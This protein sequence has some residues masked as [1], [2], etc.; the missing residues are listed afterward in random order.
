MPEPVALFL[1][2]LRRVPLAAWDR[3]ASA[4][5]L[6]APGV[7]VGA[8][9][10]SL[11]ADAVPRTSARAAWE[12][13]NAALVTMPGLAQRI[14]R[15]VDDHLAVCEGMATKASAARMRVAA[16]LAAAALAVR[17]LLSA[18]EF[19]DLYGPFAHLIPAAPADRR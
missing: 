5:P 12:R 7:E 13:V 14:A 15:R 16:H 19:D 9:A 3:C 10:G 8:V 1:H 6:A 18:R 2:A 11:S 17:P 4:C